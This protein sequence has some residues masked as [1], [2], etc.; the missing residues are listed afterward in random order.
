MIKRIL[1]ATMLLLAAFVSK[2]QPVVSGSFGLTT[3]TEK[4]DGDKQVQTF[5]FNITPSVGYVFG[6]WEFGLIFE[7]SHNKIKRHTNN[8]TETDAYY[9]V[10]PYANYCFA[11]VGKLYFSAEAYSML[12]FADGEHSVDIQLLPVATYEINDRWD[13]DFYSDILSVNYQWT[14]TDDD[15]TTSQLNILSNYGK[16][17]GI[18]FTY[19]F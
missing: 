1:F 13:I 14:K 15:I 12:G 11:N 9:A 4:F 3:I 16:L 10:G 18:G 7:Y 5:G 2:A 17:F 19:K 6:D 8:T